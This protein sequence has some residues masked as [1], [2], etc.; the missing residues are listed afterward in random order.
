M[1]EPPGGDPNLERRVSS[2]EAEMT[3]PRVDVARSVSDAAAARV[4]AGGADRDVSEMRAEL[5]AHTGVLNALRE[6]Q[7]EMKQESDRR[8]DQVD[9]RFDQVE[10][11]LGEVDRRF[12]QV[13]A[14]LRQIA[15]MLQTLIDQDAQES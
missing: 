4:L 1:S 10:G 12:G 14:G 7:L 15:G 11:R 3:Q 8:F 5:R 2:L 13:D 9:R 6:T